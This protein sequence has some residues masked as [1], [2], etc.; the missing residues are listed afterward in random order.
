MEKDKCIEGKLLSKGIKEYKIIRTI[1]KSLKY[2]EYFG[3]TSIEELL[4]DKMLVRFKTEGG[5]AQFTVSSFQS[6][7]IIDTIIEASIKN[8]MKMSFQWHDD[9]FSNVKIEQNKN[10]NRFCSF[11]VDD[12]I[13]WINEEMDNVLKEIKLSLNTV[14]TV[15]INK[16]CLRT[17]KVYLEQYNADSEFLCVENIK[18]KRKA[19]LS[20]IF[21]KDHIVDSIIENLNKAEIQSNNINLNQ[22]QRIL[23]KAEGVSALLN[24]YIL[25]YYSNYVYLNQSFIKT[26]YIGKQISKSNFDLIAMPYNGI[27]F[28]SEGSRILKKVIVESGK[29]VNLL[30]NN[31]YSKYLNLNSFGNASLDMPNTI[32]HQQLIFKFKNSERITYEAIDLIIYQFEYANMDFKNNEFRGI[33]ICSDESGYFRTPISFNIKDAFDN[34]YPVDDKS[35]WINNVYCQD[36]IIL[37]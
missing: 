15:N 20:N 33:A 12:Y 5:I 9:N 36:V 1:S 24:S 26:N 22:K 7:N 19:K 31:S 32:S 17:N 3:K 13:M 18:F 34:I 35:T 6:D 29:L 14:Y 30:S 23:I 25:M 4:E 37:R 2:I 10:Y 28:D 16:Y 8:T 11:S 21:F 27:K